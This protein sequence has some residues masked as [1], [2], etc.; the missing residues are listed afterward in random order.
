MD[1]RPRRSIAALSKSDTPIDP[2]VYALYQG[3]DASFLH[4]RILTRGT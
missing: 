1:A 3:S 4:L 2:G